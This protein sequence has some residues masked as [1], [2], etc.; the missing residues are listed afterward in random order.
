[1]EHQRIMLPNDLPA[2]LLPEDLSP[3]PSLMDDSAGVAAEVRRAAL[4]DDPEGVAAVAPYVTDAFW[5][6]LAETSEILRHLTYIDGYEW[7][8]WCRVILRKEQAPDVAAWFRKG[9]QI[10]N[11][12]AFL[13]TLIVTDWEGDSK[14][15]RVQL[16]PMIRSLNRCA[17]YAPF[18]SKIE[19]DGRI[20]AAIE[21]DRL[22]TKYTDLLEELASAYRH[23]MYCQSVVEA[24]PRKAV[25]ALLP[26]HGLGEQL[27]A[28]DWDRDFQLRCYMWDYGTS[29][30]DNAAH[31]YPLAHEWFES[32]NRTWDYGASSLRLD[33]A[34][35]S[36]FLEDYLAWLDDAVAA[37]DTSNADNVRALALLTA[38]SPH[39]THAP[40][41]ETV[42]GWFASKRADLARIMGQTP[43][44]V[45]RPC[46]SSSTDIDWRDGLFVWFKQEEGNMFAG[47]L[48][49]VDGECDLMKA[50]ERSGNGIITHQRS[51]RS[52][53]LVEQTRREPTAWQGRD[54]QGRPVFIRKISRV[55]SNA[56]K[57]RELYGRLQDALADPKGRVL[58]I[59]EDFDRYVL[60]SATHNNDS[61]TLR[62][63]GGKNARYGLTI[64]DVD[65]VA[66]TGCYCTDEDGE[67]V[68]L[69]FRTASPRSHAG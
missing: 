46:T 51:G 36:S 25:M 22:N 44:V 3:Y 52:V 60:R 69:V 61:L 27:A 23:A 4:R 16:A 62:Y 15:N 2:P 53:L 48:V 38:A 1:M 24:L 63:G 56:E 32:W 35:S 57:L 47:T 10:P 33:A 67:S 14:S 41:Q 6:I 21:G 55:T 11:H 45:S 26:Q 18:L 19:S 54:D 37:W 8:K 64:T 7:M 66:L 58:V 30:D 65:D 68:K 31:S 34:T 29:L 12:T 43:K 40:T 50:F 5:T 20:K 9:A 17:N 42:Y 59:L 49:S 13:S 39:L 28:I